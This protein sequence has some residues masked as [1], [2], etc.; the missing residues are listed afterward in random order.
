MVFNRYILVLSSKLPPIIFGKVLA[1][2][3]SSGKFN[4][5]L[6]YIQKKK[7]WDDKT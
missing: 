2:F 5:C 4:N 3:N 7:N 1:D 6:R